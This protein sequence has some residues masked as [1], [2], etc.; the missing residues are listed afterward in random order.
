MNNHLPHKLSAI[1]YAD[2]AEY[3]RLTGDDEDEVHSSVLPSLELT[4]G[5][6]CGFS[7]GSPEAQS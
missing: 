3:S 6:G 7:E 1:L 4:K 5:P 2:V